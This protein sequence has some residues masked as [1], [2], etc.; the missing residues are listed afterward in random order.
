MEHNLKIIEQIGEG[1]FSKLYS[2]YDFQ[3]N[4]QVALKI[5]KNNKRKTLLKNEFEIYNSLQNLSCIPKIYNYIQNITNEKDE[6]KQLNCI[7]ME[8]LGKN[9]LN[10]K[11]TFNYYNNI[12]VYDIL[13]QCL[14]CIKNIHDFGFIHRDI[15]PSNF[16]LHKDD[17]K[18]ILSNYKN[19]KYF[20]NEI[21][22]YLIDFGLVQKLNENK[23]KN[24]QITEM[25]KRGFIGTLTYASL[26]AHNK[27]DLSKK[28]DLWSFFF[29][30][31]D[32]LNENLP[33]RNCNGDNNE[34]EIFECKKKCIEYPEKYLF[35]T[36]SKNN[37]EINNIFNYIKNLKN[38]TEPDYEYIS[39]QLSILKNKEIQKIYYK[40]E[41][42][43]QI[44]NLQKN[45]MV[46]NDTQN[47]NNNI[48]EKN[49]NKNLYLMPQ[50]DYLIYKFSKTS[51]KSIPSLNSTN[52]TSSI[53]YKTNY[54]NCISGNNNENFYQS[55]LKSGNNNSNFN[56]NN[57]NL[58]NNISLFNSKKYFD[59]NNNIVN[60]HPYKFQAMEEN[61]ECQKNTNTNSCAKGPNTGGNNKKQEENYENDKSL[62]ESL[63]GKSQSD[64][65]IKSVNKCNKNHKKVKNRKMNIHNKRKNIKFSI[66]KTEK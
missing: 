34:N 39:N 36:I 30:L 58:V 20:K 26:N 59:F 22:V 2:A 32:L 27:E 62:I 52:Y 56:K 42:K 37:K 65:P 23:N 63:I 55:V 29:M 54:I 8:L 11:K 64:S 1:A 53:Y 5:E 45:L 14:N 51:N 66:V 10:F 50:Q 46:K 44:L 61:L 31:L 13:L 7:E 18:K 3:L 47:N 24:I 4:K 28:D 60:I 6:N 25:N 19:N 35:L 15:K 9:L 33:W 43:N 38:E 49:N 21:N 41:I 12:L 40:Y 17:E 57:A 48:Y 16:C